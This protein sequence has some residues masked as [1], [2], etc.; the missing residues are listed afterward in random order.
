MDEEFDPLDE[1]EE[2]QDD[3]DDGMTPDNQEAGE[4]DEAYEIDLSGGEEE[5]SGTPTDQKPIDEGKQET[6][7]SVWEAPVAIAFEAPN[8][9]NMT[10]MDWEENFSLEK[11]SSLPENP[12]NDEN[13]GDNEDLNVAGSSEDEE[14]EED[15]DVPMD[16]MPAR[17]RF[18]E[19]LKRYEQLKA[20]VEQSA[21]KQRSLAMEVLIAKRE[22]FEREEEN[23]KEED[24][25][26][27]AI[28]RKRRIAEKEE[29]AAA[30][31][32]AEA[33]QRKAQQAA[34]EAEK[35]EFEL[36]E[37]S[38]VRQEEAAAKDE[39]ELRELKA[40]TDT[41]LAWRQW[42]K[43]E[44]VR[45]TRLNKLS[46][47]QTLLTTSQKQLAV[48]LTLYE[49]SDVPFFE[50]LRDLEKAANSRLWDL[51]SQTQVVRA[52]FVVERAAREESVYQMQDRLKELQQQLEDARRDEAVR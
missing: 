41:E 25:A 43:T 3:E 46:D 9:W 15:N 17:E 16:P 47:R 36:L 22:L 23:L 11:S 49:D 35:V 21:A 4:D 28:E 27:I 18:E 42:E 31:A 7:V 34:A 1:E 8:G 13:Q 37:K 39:S 20:D 40:F 6:G 24:A 52:R 19:E 2:R 33:Q 12:D 50:R 14:D 26:V 51:Q 38:A 32:K 5:G 30:K 48:D 29:Q 10:T 44:K 45:N